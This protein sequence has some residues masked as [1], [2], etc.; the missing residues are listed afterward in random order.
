[1]DVMELP[2]TDFDRF[3]LF[4]STA[5]QGRG[6]SYRKEMPDKR[7]IQS[8]GRISLENNSCQIRQQ[9]KLDIYFL[10]E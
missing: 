6:L 8:L 7:L 4:I 5:L 3:K 2:H 1:M 10:I 9:E